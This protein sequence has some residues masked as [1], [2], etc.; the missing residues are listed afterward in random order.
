MKRTVALTCILKNELHNLQRFCES[1]AG[2]F[3]EY[4]FTDTGSEDGSVAWLMHDAEKYL[5]CSPDQLHIHHFKWI[6][7]FSAARNMAIPFI[8]SDYWMWMDLDD[9]LYNK[10]SFLAW[11]KE[12]INFAEFWYVPYHYALKEIKYDGEPAVSFIRERIIK[13]SLGFRFK[14]FVHEGIDIR[15]AG[16][17]VESG[18]VKSFSVKH[19]RT[20]DEMLAD[21]GRNISL[22]EM[23]KNN[24][25][26][27]L[28]F[29]Y[30][31]E[32]FDL[33]KYQECV[34]ILKENVKKKEVEQGDRILA[35]QYLIHSLIFTE[36]YVDAIQYGILGIQME[37]NRAEYHCLVGEAYLR[38]NEP[39][40]AVPFFSA[41]KY[42]MNAASQGLS[43]EFSYSEGYS[44]IPRMNL[45]QIFTNVQ[46]FEKAIDEL[47]PIKDQYPE[48]KALY[49][50][51]VK[52][53]KST[54]IPKDEELEQT[55]DVVITCINQNAYPWDEKIYYEK[56]LGGS[57]TAAVEM[58]MHLK[59]LTTG[60]VII[61]QHRDSDWVS[62][63]GVEYI[64][65]PELHE[66]FQ[67]YKPALHVAW[68]HVGKFTNAKSVVWSHDLMTLG[69]ENHQN[70]DFMLALSGAHRD[71]LVGL[72]DVPEDKIIIT[73]NGINP[74]RFKDVGVIKKEYARVIWPN[75]PDRGLEWAIK[76][77][78]L[79]VKEIPEATLHCYY[80]FDNMKKY[81]LAER[82]KN[83]E[84]MFCTRPWIK[85]HGNVPQDI[86]AEDFM[87][88]EVWLYTSTF[89][90]TFCISAIEA[91]SARAYP[92][93]RRFGALKNTMS[94]AD[95]KGWADIL[96]VDMSDE[97]VPLFADRVIAAI[98]EKKHEKIDF[99]PKNASWLSVANDWVSIFNLK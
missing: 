89:Y 45:A 44:F 21:K 58:A 50:F 61:F 80:G 75:S 52:A 26:P 78:D 88:S 18:A 10:T 19:L 83:I 91:L 53:I 34:D 17:H 85:Y 30:G 2:C 87:K 33:K 12:G 11:K 62:P 49:D 32:L 81:G 90:E 25:S 3:D 4:H 84:N 93:V 77:M 99:D 23:N 96:D 5:Q 6:N 20:H 35:F 28:E 82:A 43:H 1:V 98:K 7:D 64:R 73:R 97:T 42:C 86:L 69:A 31:K 36:K 71:F 22:L 76:V 41:A 39:F 24:L 47:M 59:K 27:R 51:N 70:Y 55:N 72:H 65:A 79:V 95:E 16:K 57:E 37:P 54:T 66:Y 68:R 46:Q 92:V 14:D 29:Y 15:D 13:T 63:S 38:M 60:R 56:G 40:K 9:V 74:D 48:A 8:K 94:E 67:K